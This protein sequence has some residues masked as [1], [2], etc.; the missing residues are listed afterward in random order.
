ML[1]TGEIVAIV[2]GSGGVSGA[3]N[4]GLT[5]WLM[6][7]TRRRDVSHQSLLVAEHLEAYA[8]GCAGQAFGT[9]CL[10]VDGS[11]GALMSSPPLFQPFPDKIVWQSV[12]ARHAEAAR[13]LVLKSE[14]A[15]GAVQAGFGKSATEGHVAAF[16]WALRLGKEAC[17]VAAALRASRNIRPLAFDQPRWDYPVFLRGEFERLV[18]RRERIAVEVAAAESRAGSGR[19][20]EI[21]HE[22][23]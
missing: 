14:Q 19:D 3:V 13:A 20:S 16:A 8:F 9:W 1:G 17:E 5:H 22:E 23:S 21:E 4:F 10:L 11:P 15:A 2:L 6:L 7:R 18:D 12:E